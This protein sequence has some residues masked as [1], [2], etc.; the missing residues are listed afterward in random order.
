MT[1]YIDL[2]KRIARRYTLPP[3][4]AITHDDLIQEACLALLEQ[5]RTLENSGS[6]PS[7]I[8]V[9]SD[10]NPWA[11]LSGE[12]RGEAYVYAIARKAMQRAI[13]AY[14]SPV[15]RSLEKTLH[16]DDNGHAVTLADNIPDD[17]LTPLQQ[18]TRSESLHALRM[19]IRALNPRQQ[20]IL[21]RLFAEGKTAVE[22]ARE[23]GTS[24][25]RIRV[26][27]HELLRK[28]KKTV[29]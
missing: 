4:C 6:S 25:V 14:V 1:Q 9:P 18:I 7:P 21:H 19:S 13:S 12:A 10:F 22:V 17:A 11:E 5:S 16:T 24:D 29:K 23:L 26:I 15:T 28:L 8:G 20:L 3:K 27:K 2:I